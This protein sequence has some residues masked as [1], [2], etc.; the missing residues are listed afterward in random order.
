MSDN[1]TLA[2]VARII[3]KVY[4]DVEGEITASSNFEELGMDSLTRID[5]LAAVEGAFDLEVPDDQVAS[6][7]TVQDLLDFLAANRAGV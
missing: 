6:L 7:V 3:T 1:E 4:P 2:E 5:L